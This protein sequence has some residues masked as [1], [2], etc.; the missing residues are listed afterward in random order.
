MAGLTIAQLLGK[1][2]G[3]SAESTQT[4]G[5]LEIRRRVITTPSRTIAIANISNVSVGWVEHRR[6]RWLLV[7]LIAGIPGGA[8]FNSWEQGTRSMGMLLLLA[9]IAFVFVFFLLPHKKHYLLITTNDGVL[10]RFPGRKAELLHEVRDVL[11]EKINTGNE[12]ISLHANFEKG[13]I[14]NLNVAHA[15]SVNQTTNVSGSGH[16]VATNGAT[17]VSGHANT[18]QTANGANG[19]VGTTETINNVTRSPGAQ[20]G[21]GHSQ[22]GASHSNT[23]RYVD[24][25]Q[26][27][28]SIVEMHRFYARQPNAEHLEQRLHELELLMRAGATGGHQ[29]SRI[30]ELAGEVGQILQAYP[31]AVQIFQHIASLV[32]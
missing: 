19:R 4:F 8:L 20:L 9:A 15:D 21:N 26:F 13:S 14:E 23:E 11:T 30:R 6:W 2:T 24:F 5:E 10:S 7:A 3:E 32:S 27:L 18:V 16:T 22:N 28:P 17:A 31:A 1:A 25:S 29:K 12:N